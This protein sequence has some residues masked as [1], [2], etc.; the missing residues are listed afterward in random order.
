MTCGYDLRGQPAAAALRCP[1]CGRLSSYRRMLAIAFREP[2]FRWWVMPLFFVP[3]IA[4]LAWTDLAPTSV[5]P[6]PILHVLGGMMFYAMAYYALRNHKGADR[7]G[8]A[9]VLTIFIWHTNVLM[10]MLLPLLS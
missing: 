1:E 4:L 9:V 7:V 5:P 3:V 10:A 6:V 8:A 2:A